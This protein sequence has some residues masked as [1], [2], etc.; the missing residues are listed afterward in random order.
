MSLLAPL[1]TLKIRLFS[2]FRIFKN[3]CQSATNRLLIRK[4]T[5]TVWKLQTIKVILYSNLFFMFSQDDTFA[6]KLDKSLYPVIMATIQT[7]LRT[8][9]HDTQRLLLEVYISNVR[10]VFVF[11]APLMKK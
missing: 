2:T 4:K 11:F 7:P 5:L 1:K 8:A 6:L 9:F 3:C 10:S